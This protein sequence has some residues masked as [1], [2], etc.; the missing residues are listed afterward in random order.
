ML[1]GGM[2]VECESNEGEEDNEEEDQLCGWLLVGS[3]AI[4]LAAPAVHPVCNLL[5]LDFLCSELP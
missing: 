1:S 3:W 5:E 2:S 4:P